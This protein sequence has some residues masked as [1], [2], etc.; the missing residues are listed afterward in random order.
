MTD[1]PKELGGPVLAAHTASRLEPNNYQFRLRLTELVRELASSSSAR[2]YAYHARGGASI[3]ILFMIFLHPRCFVVTPSYKNC[4]LAATV[5]A[6]GAR[7]AM[8][9]AR[10]YKTLRDHVKM[11]RQEWVKT[12]EIENVNRRG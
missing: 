12:I 4:G 8:A 6:A 11:S 1:P 5:L 3:L 2:A 7:L 9:P 10:H